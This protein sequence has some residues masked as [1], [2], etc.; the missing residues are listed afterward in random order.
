[1][2]INTFGLLLNVYAALFAGNAAQ[3]DAS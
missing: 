3:L 2:G 1:V